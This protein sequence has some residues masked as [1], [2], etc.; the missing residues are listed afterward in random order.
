MRYE[1]R[2]Q[3]LLPARLFA[4]RVIAHALIALGLLAFALGIGIVGYHATERISWLDSLLSASMILGGMG[5]V[6]VLHTRAGK[7]FAS[8]YA[9]FAGVLFLAVVGVI[10][11]PIA[12][13][14]LHRLHAELPEERR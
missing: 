12:H 9:L 14:L 11:A 3:P 7:L 10:M 6:D 2:S 8:F 4:R 5:P 13:R 1:H